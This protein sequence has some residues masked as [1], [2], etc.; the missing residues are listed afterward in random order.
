MP[1]RSRSGLG[2][3][4]SRAGTGLMRSLLIY[5]SHETNQGRL[6]LSKLRMMLRRRRAAYLFHA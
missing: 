5:Q 4:H 1:G 2:V 3:P 6:T